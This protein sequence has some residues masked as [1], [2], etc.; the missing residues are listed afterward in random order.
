VV[1]TGGAVGPPHAVAVG[2]LV[3]ADNVNGY[4]Y[5][6]TTGGTVPISGSVTL[7]FQAEVAGESRNVAHNTIDI[8]QTPLAGVTINNPSPT[9]ITSLGTNEESDATLRTR[10]TSRWSTLSYASPEDAYVQFALAAGADD[11]TRAHVHADNPGGPGTVWVFIAGATGPAI[12]GD[13][14]TAQDYIDTRRPATADVTVFAAT[15]QVQNFDAIIYVNSAD[16]DGPGGSKETE[17]ENALEAH[18]NNL[19]IGGTILPPG[20]NGY[21]VHSEVTCDVS[22]IQGVDG[23]AWTNPTGDVSVAHN[24]VM[25]VGAI[26]FTYTTI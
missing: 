20:P 23:I 13:V 17:I 12:A 22:N 16:Y 11:V 18:V 3:A 19:P 7:T 9:W 5:R 1:L 2:Q 25:T 14:T 10:C 26:A 24:S 21:L 6:N 15:A 8:L 4:T